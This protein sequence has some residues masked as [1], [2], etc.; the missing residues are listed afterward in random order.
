MYL[1]KALKDAAKRLSPVA[2]RKT[3]L[4]NNEEYGKGVFRVSDS[5]ALQCRYSFIYTQNNSPYELNETMKL[6]LEGFEVIY[7]EYHS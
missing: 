3:Y 1:V 2:L 4:E 7:P 6:T 5:H